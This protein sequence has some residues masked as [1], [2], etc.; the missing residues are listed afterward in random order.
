MSNSTFPIPHFPFPIFKI[1]FPTSFP[2]F[3]SHPHLPSTFPILQLPYHILHP[4]F[5][6]P[7]L[8]FKF[9]SLKICCQFVYF[10]YPVFNVT[11]FRNQ[12]TKDNRTETGLLAV[13]VK[14]VMFLG[15]LKQCI[16]WNNQQYH[17][18]VIFTSYYFSESR[19]TLKCSC[20]IPK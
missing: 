11:Y 13:T 6:I 2:K 1:H 16:A 14:M 19:T 3:I 9:P 15:V 20:L 4:P 10:Q 17:W 7:P 5:H 18:K 8:H 12:C